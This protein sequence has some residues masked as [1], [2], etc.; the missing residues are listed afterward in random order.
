MVKVRDNLKRSANGQLDTDSW[1]EQLCNT[2]DELD[3]ELIEKSL[4]FVRK[5]PARSEEFLEKGL[6]LASLVASLNMDTVCVAAALVYRPVRTHSV[7]PSFVEA[8]IDQD[9]SAL[10]GAVARMADT[11]LLEMTNATMQTSEARDQVENVRRMLVS[12]IDDARVAILKL[13]E[14]VLALRAA[15]NSSE[16]R[17]RRIA[18]EAHLVFVPLANRLGIWRLKWE[19]E[20]LSLRYLVPDVYQA[21]AG[22]LDG[23]REERES[24]VLEIVKGVEER[25]RRN[26]IDATVTGRAKHIFSIWR[27][28]QVKN[29]ALTEVYDV[30]AIRVLVP[31]IAQ[32]YASLGIIHTQWQ[33]IPSEFDDYIAVPKENGYRSIHTAV[34]GEDGKTLEV[35]IRTPDMHEESELGV[36]AHWSYKDGEKE[37]RPY[38]EKMDWLRQVVEWQEETRQRIRS[39]PLRDELKKRIH[40]ERIFVYTPQG[41]VLDLTTGATPVDFAYRVHTEVGNH[42]CE[43]RVDGEMVALNTSLQT[44]QRVEIV[45][46]KRQGPQRVWLDNHL[47]FVKTSRAR[48]KIEEWFHALDSQTNFDTGHEL[49]ISMV[50][51]LGLAAPT[52]SQLEALA[53]RLGYGGV[54]AIFVALGAGDCQILDLLDGLYRSGAVPAQMSLLP[55][56][57]L[58]SNIYNI[59]VRA[60]DRDGLLLDITTFLSKHSVPLLSNTGAVDPVTNEAS[61][62]FS[63][64]LSGIHELV[65]VIDGL[66]QIPMVIDVRRI[67]NQLLQD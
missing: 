15:K 64:R 10:V 51:R 40:E 48:E 63:A 41:H 11:S 42:C 61:I 34:M 54:E 24:Q 66:R 38:T 16:E 55:G 67:E 14:R 43:A 27:K 28:M 6:E 49:L 62:A 21:I 36:C 45:T 7:E 57:A 13:A 37:D 33:F 8:E 31:D 39:D 44:G 58:A 2:Y 52:E 47:D 56:T 1:Q 23:R 5:L 26:A 9:V 25:L 22:Q 30:R 4:S 32:C 18:Q 46:D 65:Q 3:S 60:R 20:D 59:D 19:L 53:V 12:M 50:D 29:V 17:Q 35:Q